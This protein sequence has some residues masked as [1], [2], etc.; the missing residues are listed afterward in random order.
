MKAC[1]SLIDLPSS[2][3]LLTQLTCLRI[4][5]CSG[6]ARLPACVSGLRGLLSL[7]IESSRLNYLPKSISQLSTLTFLCLD[8]SMTP[9]C[10][11][12]VA[13]E[14]LEV[15][16]AKQFDLLSYL[17][18]FTRITSLS[19]VHCQGGELPPSFTHLQRLEVLSVKGCRRLVCPIAL[20][21]ALPCLHRLE[22]SRCEALSAP[23]QTEA[24]AGPALVTLGSCTLVKLG[25]LSRLDPPCFHAM[26]AVKAMSLAGV[27]ATELPESLCQLAQLTSLTVCDSKVLVSLS[28]SFGQLSALRGLELSSL[29]LLAG[30]PESFGCL[31]Q[32][33]NLRIRNCKQLAGLP[34]TFGSFKSLRKLTFERCRLLSALREVFYEL[35]TLT[36]IRVIA[37]PRLGGVVKGLKGDVIACPR[38]GGCNCLNI[39]TMLGAS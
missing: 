28:P 9:A 22:M 26:A 31:Q 21:A 24:P 30:L 23:A 18:P 16:G 15:R 3:S 36:C 20:L 11:H 38:L 39:C 5:R 27:Q 19:L 10:K 12:L 6:L 37:C 8:G 35:Q 33:R 29:P 32:L 4:E 17:H 2:M 25:S 7:T 1:D 13:L 34:G 14:K